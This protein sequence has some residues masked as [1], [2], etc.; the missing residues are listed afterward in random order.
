M[1]ITDLKKL[2]DEEYEA[3]NYDLARTLIRKTP[4]DLK[5][6]IAFHVESSLRDERYD[7]LDRGKIFS[8]LLPVWRSEKIRISE[9]KPV[10]RETLA[11]ALGTNENVTFFQHSLSN[12]PSALLNFSQEHS[13]LSS[14]I[15]YHDY[16]SYRSHLNGDGVRDKNTNDVF[17]IKNCIFPSCFWYPSRPNAIPF[18]EDGTYIERLLTGQKNPHLLN[19][20]Y[21]HRA[22][23]KSEIDCVFVM[24][25]AY[26]NGFWH[27]IQNSL[28]TLSLYKKLELDCPIII[29]NVNFS[30]FPALMDAL[31]MVMDFL[32]ISKSRIISP[33][34]Y[35]HVKSNVAIAPSISHPSTSTVQF[36]NDVFDF[37]KEINTYPEFIYLSRSAKGRRC[38]LNEKEV[39]NVFKEYGFSVFDFNEMSFMEQASVF[40]SAKIIAS[41]HGAGLVHLNFCT[42]KPTVLEFITKP[43]N[44]SF[45]NGTALVGGTYVP[46][47]SDLSK[48]MRLDDPDASFYIDIKKLANVVETLMIDFEK[49]HNNE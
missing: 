7:S 49:G 40:R 11:D 33:Q 19:F 35:V 30:R 39:E 1:P 13:Q 6:D 47:I 21:A 38:I 2:I 48:P 22:E 24:P 29:P 31:D 27:F 37:H 41:P 15:L 32:R 5:I 3:E 25:G 36:W 8:T 9:A 44:Q 20:D 16:R 45:S 26:G 46:F 43:W 18:T 28:P 17:V 4:D 10:K 12:P 23:I 34:D 42:E 14:G